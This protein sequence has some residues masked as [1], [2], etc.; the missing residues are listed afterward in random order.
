M[1]NQTPL[2]GSTRRFTSLVASLGLLIATIIV[3]SLLVSPTYKE[4]NQL[5]GEM[6]SRMNV[7]EEQREIIAKVKELLIQYQSVAQVRDTISLIL[8]TD[9]DYSTLINQINGLGKAAN[10][11]VEAISLSTTP[12]QQSVSAG[13]R[14]AAPRVSELRF[15]V[16]ASGTYQ[17]LKTFLQVLETNMRIMDL[18]SLGINPGTGTGQNYLYNIVATTYYQTL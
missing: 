5:R 12:V 4:I 3:Y 15:T 7:L 2:K 16:Q 9:E 1:Q 17:S 18:N 10:M 13:T 14:A 11:R 6:L 8:P